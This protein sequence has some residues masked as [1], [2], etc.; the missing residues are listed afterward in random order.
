M[1]W[2]LTFLRLPGR[3]RS[4]SQRAQ[5]HGTHPEQ[6]KKPMWTSKEG[7]TA[8]G[9]GWGQGCKAEAEEKTGLLKPLCQVRILDLSWGMGS[10]RRL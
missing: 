9:L 7:A 3:S 8:G 1:L 4:R 2:D 5:E 10:L 6:L